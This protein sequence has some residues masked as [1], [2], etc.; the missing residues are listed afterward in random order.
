MD[1]IDCKIIVSN[2]HVF[3]KQASQ[4]LGDNLKNMSISEDVS[5]SEGMSNSETK[6]GMLKFK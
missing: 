5:N 2:S 3:S 4:Y 1:E 6:I